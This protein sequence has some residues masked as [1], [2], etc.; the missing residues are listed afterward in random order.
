MPSKAQQ[1]NA[2]S[3]IPTDAKTNFLHQSDAEFLEKL[4]PFAKFKERSRQTHHQVHVPELTARLQLDTTLP[5]PSEDASPPAPD[6]LVPNLA[7]TSPISVV[8]LGNSMLERFKTSGITTDIGKL[9]D[10][11]VAFNAGVGGDSNQNVVYR[12]TEGLYDM[13]KTA[14]K[15]VCDIKLWI[16]ASGT[17]NLQ[18]KRAFRKQDVESWRVLV[19][20]CL[21]I[22]PESTVLACDISYRLDIPDGIVDQSNKMLREVVGEINGALRVEKEHELQTC[23]DQ[24]ERDRED[25]VKW[26]DT[27]HMFIK[28][29]LDD[30]VHLNEEGYW[31][32]DFVLWPHVARVLVVPTEEDDQLLD[33]T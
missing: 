21:R 9:G 18:K 12:L 7:N 26:V 10:T 4:R 13:L 20:A 22:A 25:K 16:V 3:S 1:S 23:E 32:W 30:H 2:A 14:K 28:N 15:D 24:T 33:W 6:A 29:M 19:E 5:I 17:N 8:Y 11:G 31:L 27:R